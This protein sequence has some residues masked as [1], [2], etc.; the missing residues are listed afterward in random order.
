MSSS[1][2][3]SFRPHPS[4]SVSHLIFLSRLY[5]SMAGREEQP[6][7]GFSRQV[8]ALSRAM[9]RKAA[10]EATPLADRLPL[11]SSLYGL[12][13][14]T[15]Y[16]VDRRK[17]ERWDTLAE[18]LIHAAWAPARAGEEEILTPL[19][20][21]LADYFYFDPAPEED[22]WFLFLRDTVTRFGEGLASSPHWEGLSLEESLARIGLMNRYSYMFLDHRWDRLVGEAFRHYAA[23]ALSASS[24][25]PAVWGR[26]YDLSTEGNACPMDESLAAKAWERIVRTA[27]PYAWPT[28]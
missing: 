24:P 14:G 15:S 23:R 26:L 20:L 4:D 10:S 27:I 2:F 7:S 21:C 9:F 28:S 12:L 8:D 3:P 19:C 1:P 22:P 18:K 25:S 5:V 6:V 16:I 13:N 11:L 17:T